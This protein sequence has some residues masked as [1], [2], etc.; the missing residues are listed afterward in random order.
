MLNEEMKQ[1]AIDYADIV[2]DMVD[3]RIMITPVLTATKDEWRKI[4]FSLLDLVNAIQN[5]ANLPINLHVIDANDDLQETLI[6]IDVENEEKA[7]LKDGTR[8]DD[9]V[10]LEEE[11][12]INDV[13]YD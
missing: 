4:I 1:Q 13:R 7:A 11:E 3:P 9:A 6:A 8:P 5:K 2:D 10:V 12:F